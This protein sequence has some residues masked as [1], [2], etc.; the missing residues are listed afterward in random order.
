MFF[1]PPSFRQ[2]TLIDFHIIFKLPPLH[3]PPPLPTER[4]FKYL[5][6]PGL[7]KHGFSVH[8]LFKMRLTDPHIIVIRFL[9]RHQRAHWNVFQRPDPCRTI[10]VIPPTTVI[11]NSFQDLLEQRRITQRIGHCLLGNIYYNRLQ[12]FS[13][14]NTKNPA[15][16][17]VAIP[18]TT[19]RTFLNP[20]PGLFASKK[21]F[22]HYVLSIANR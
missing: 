16:G 5:R 21:S 1:N 9:E 4:N 18:K 3:H 19:R 13:A 12:H 10:L 2:L 14:I 11:L 15:F 8:H 6:Q 17:K 7:I 22:V 20:K